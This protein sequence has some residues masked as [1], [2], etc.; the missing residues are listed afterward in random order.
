[1]K[2]R[3]V[4]LLALAL[5]LCL[6]VCG[7][8]AF[9]E[10]AEPEV[11]DMRVYIDGLLTCRGYARGG[12]AL[13]PAED[14][15]RFFHV[16]LSVTRDDTA[17]KYVLLAPSLEAEIGDGKEYLL[18][19]QRYF[20]AP[21]GAALIGGELYLPAEALTRLLGLGYTLTE[22]L[23][24]MD[25]DSAEMQLIRGSSTYY[26]DNFGTDD[27]FWLARIIHAEAANQ[28]LAGQIGVGNVVFNRVASELY[29]D[30][31]ID[32]IFDQKH[33]IQFE[34]VLR[35]TVYAEPDEQSLIAACLC[36]EGYNTVEDCMY[37]VN[38][39]MADDSWFRGSLSF[40]ATIGDHDFY[41]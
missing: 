1:M 17:G 3:T 36:L 11:T 5:L 22:D 24:R 12:T 19:N 27:V 40:Y 26:S 39:A 14:I 13:L 18:A 21:G 2:S 6:L 38:P 30:T 37:F 34:P 7:V 35:G 32:V 31:V 28:P 10:E 25:I 33:N 20:Y 29:P 8:P 23:R 9:A 41:R 15:C 4:K 16:E